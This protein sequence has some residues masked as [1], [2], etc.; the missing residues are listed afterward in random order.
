M[1]AR[2]LATECPTVTMGTPV[3]DAI[4][5]VAD[6]GLPGIVVVDDAGHPMR[7]LPGALVLRLAVPPYCLEDPIL[8]R[9]A[10]DTPAAIADALSGRSVG[11]CLGQTSPR[12]LAVTSDA[13]ALE[14]ASLM[15]STGSELVA[16]VDDGVLKGA[17][18]MQAVIRD[19][20]P[21]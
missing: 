15:A 16:V 8:A 7:V 6:D 14:I 20:V 21:A 4:A 10:D 19:L 5:C 17:V 13:T 12:L 3:L 9:V 11:Q 18:S 1:R 2:E